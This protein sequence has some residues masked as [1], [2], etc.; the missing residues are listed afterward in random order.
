MVEIIPSKIL[1]GDKRV[2]IKSFIIIALI[3]SLISIELPFFYP[4]PIS[5]YK[6]SI[7]FNEKVE[8]GDMDVKFDL[9]ETMKSVL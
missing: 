5:T 3:F 8:K 4:K 7:R 9:K 1:Y 6:L 2:I